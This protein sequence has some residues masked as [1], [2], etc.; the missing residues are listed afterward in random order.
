[1]SP[2]RLLQVTRSHSGIENQLHWVLDVHFAEDRNRARKDNAPEILPS[3]ERSHSISSK[4]FL[5]RPRYA[6]KSNGPAGT[7]PF[8]C[9]QSAICDSPAASGDQDYTTSPSVRM[10]SSTRHARETSHRPPHPALNVR[11]DR[12]TPLGVRMGCTQTTTYFGKTEVRYFCPGELTCF[13]L[14]EVICQSG[15]TYLLMSPV[16]PSLPV[17][18]ELTPAFAPGSA[19]AVTS[20][21]DPKRTSTGSVHYRPKRRSPDKATA[22]LSANVSKLKQSCARPAAVTRGIR[23]H[24]VMVTHRGALLLATFAFAW[25][26]LVTRGVNGDTWPIRWW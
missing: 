13:R 19:S 10:P 6:A 4:R 8:C 2:K 25:H 9:R 18:W 26:N 20:H 24:Q 1:M 21:F 5:F 14:S 23:Q 3:C 12:E 11:D 17:R 15:R 22:Q 7:M 16:D